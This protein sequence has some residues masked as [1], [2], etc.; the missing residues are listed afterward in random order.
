MLS[1]TEGM[2]LFGAYAVFIVGLV[3]LTRGTHH[4]SDDFLLMERK[5]GIARGSVS[6]AV[7]WIW[8]P[9]VFIC[10]LQAYSQG[11]PGIFWFTAPNIITFFIFVPF[12]LKMRE[13][14]PEG[15]TV[16]QLFRFKYPSDLRAHKASMV[17]SFGYQLGAIIIN[18][19][20][21]ATLINL[22]SGIPYH[23]GVIMMGALALAYSLISGLRASVLS[24]VAQMAMILVVGLVL[25]PWTL[26]EAG[27]WQIVDTGLGGVS[28]EYRNLFDIGVAIS[29]GV[30]TT[31]GLVSGPV[32]DQMFSQRAFAARKG[33]IAPIFIIGGLLFGIVPIVLSLLGFIGAGSVINESG[34]TVSDPQMVGPEVVGF[35]LPKWALMLFAVMAFAGLTSTLD[36]AFSAVGSLWAVDLRSAGETTDRRIQIAR[37]GMIVFA[38]IGVGIASLRPQLLWVFLIYGALAASVFF[39]ILLTLF[40]KKV[41]ASAAF[42]GIILGI[43]LGTPLSIYAN[44]NG[45]TALVVLAALLGLIVPGIVTT[46]LTAAASSVSNVSSGENSA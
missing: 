25:V 30:A 44:V 37:T 29:F 40:W 13:L 12:A 43:L 32:A 34:L 9:A 26:F 11:L 38:V 5:L 16:S 20:A 7:S 10:S 18:C 6:I 23:A 45:E 15:Y 46:T 2:A 31:I 24:D 3:W 33:A 39:P 22:L 42:W 17:V 36:S 1:V 21:G 35:Y 27:G 8:A 4:T 28:G 14:M 41:S 19:A